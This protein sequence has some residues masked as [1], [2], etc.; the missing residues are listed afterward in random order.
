MSM[1]G[2]VL[3]HGARSDPGSGPVD[4]QMDSTE[5]I[6]GMP[7]RLGWMLTSLTNMLVALRVPQ[8]G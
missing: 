2:Y 7:V 3:V 6:A 4:I 5:A 8:A 1:G